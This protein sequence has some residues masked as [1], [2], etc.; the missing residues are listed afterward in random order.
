MNPARD[1]S[2]FSIP[3]L[4]R[5][6]RPEKRVKVLLDLLEDIKDLLPAFSFVFSI[7]TDY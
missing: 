1:P 7:D 6:Q 3:Q 2:D 4:G 5:W